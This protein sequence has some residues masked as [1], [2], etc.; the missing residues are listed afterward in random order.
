MCEAGVSEN[1]CTALSLGNKIQCNRKMV[2][3]VP[4]T[5]LPYESMLTFHLMG[6]RQ[7]KNQE[8]L[9]W[10]VLPLFSCSTLVN[11]T[12]LLG[13]SVLVEPPG[14][15]TPSL[16]DSHQQPIGV[17]LQLDFPNEFEWRF[18]RPEVV[19]GSVLFSEPVEELHKKMSAVSKKHCLCFLTENE[20]AFLWSKRY[21][22][23]PGNTF[24]HLVL[25][26]APSW[27]PEDLPEIYSVVDHWP[28]TTPEEALFLLSDSFP[29]ATVRRSAVR[30]FEQIS[31]GELE[32]FLPQ[33]VQ[34]LKS[35]WELDG[36]L[37]MLL[38]DRSVRNIRLAQQL[39]WLLVDTL[40]D[41]HY[42]GWFSKVLAALKHCCGR[43]LR[44]ELEHQAQ[45]VALLTQVAEKVRL[46]DKSRRKEVLEREKWKIKE[47][48]SDGKTC[49]LPLDA[50]FHVKGVD[51]EACKFYNSNA[52]PLRISFICTDPLARKISVICKTGDSLRQDSLIMQIVRVMD[53][54][55][56]Q[57]G[58]DMRMVTYR[59]LSTGKDQGLVEVVQ[60]AVT[61]A[62]IQQ[63]WGLGGA[64]REDTLEKWFHMRNKTKDSYDKV[65]PPPPL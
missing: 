8:L 39:Y 47:F 9:R 28:I 22:A 61:L 29:D 17:I 38:L 48:F 11:G 12:V 25:G 3:P 64:L 45:L 6:C 7:G 16:A 24:L 20:R 54:V 33:L 10:A 50:A 56:L 44:K 14:P 55:W 40:L 26:G 4:V 27:K 59:C 37:V 43:A 35:E 60:D 34:A 13:M 30:F 62:K 5:K 57:E 46:A 42:Q 63:E 51:V 21:C 18:Q 31:H 2:F 1:I 23:N 58:L 49:R 15:P 32:V 52:T 65:T 53:R 19:P 36:A 41:A